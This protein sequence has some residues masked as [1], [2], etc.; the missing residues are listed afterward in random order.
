[1]V[2]HVHG[3]QVCKMHGVLVCHCCVLCLN[4]HVHFYVTFDSSVNWRRQTCIHAKIDAQ[5]CN[6]ACTSTSLQLHIHAHHQLLLNG[7]PPPTHTHV[8]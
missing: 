2:V 3:G 1:M 7:T 8:V 4:V 5:E 6:R